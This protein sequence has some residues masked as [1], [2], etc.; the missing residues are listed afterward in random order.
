MVCSREE[1]DNYFFNVGEMIEIETEIRINNTCN[2]HWVETTYNIPHNFSFSDQLAEVVFG[3][4]VPDNILL[5]SVRS[6][7]STSN[8]PANSYHAICL[9]K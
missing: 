8:D 4:K 3:L 1:K 6:T 7:S 9:L 2:R 5:P